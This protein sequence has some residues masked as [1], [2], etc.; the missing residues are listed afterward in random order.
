MLVTVTGFHI[1]VMQEHSEFSAISKYKPALVK[2]S[3]AMLSPTV[4]HLQ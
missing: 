2:K 4:Q 1:G 3:G